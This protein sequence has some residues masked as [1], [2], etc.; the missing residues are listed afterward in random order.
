MLNQT[1]NSRHKSRV[2]DAVKRALEDPE[3][4]FNHSFEAGIEY[5]SDG[6]SKT[7]RFVV[8]HS[9]QRSPIDSGLQDWIKDEKLL[10]WV[11]VAA[12]LP[13]SWYPRRGFNNSTAQ[14]CIDTVLRNGKGISIHSLAAVNR[15]QS[16]NSH[17]WTL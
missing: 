5:R 10:P 11:A 1:K 15:N 13:V 4:L 14:I 8:H 12:Q 7:T 3:Y 9:I 6:E 17:P 16:A 2:N